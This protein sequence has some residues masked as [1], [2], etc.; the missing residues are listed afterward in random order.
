MFLLTWRSIAGKTQTRS[1]NQHY[2]YLSIILPQL[3]I[4][5]TGRTVN[6]KGPKKEMIM[7][8]VAFKSLNVTVERKARRKEKFPEKR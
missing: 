5:E 3:I 7:G 2:L 1:Q 6:G 4:N 8:D